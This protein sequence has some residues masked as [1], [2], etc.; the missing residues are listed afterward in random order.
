MRNKVNGGFW[1]F[2][3]VSVIALSLV[4]LTGNKKPEDSE[5]Y[6]RAEVMLGMVSCEVWCDEGYVAKCEKNKKKKQVVCYCQQK[7]GK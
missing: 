2:A 1:F 6:C 4:V 3:T 7:A 5:R